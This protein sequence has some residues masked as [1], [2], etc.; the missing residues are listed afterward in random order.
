M[1]IRFRRRLY[2]C[3]SR[4]AHLGRKTHR[5]RK[6]HIWGI[7]T[8]HWFISCTGAQ[9][10][11]HYT[12]YTSAEFSDTVLP[13]SVRSSRRPWLLPCSTHSEAVTC[14]RPGA[15][16]PRQSSVLAKEAPVCRHTDTGE[17]TPVCRHIRHGSC[18][19]ARP[20]A[21]ARVQPRHQPPNKPS[22]AA[23][24]TDTAAAENRPL[25]A[26]ST[27]HYGAR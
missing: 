16:R 4:V 26:P 10:P 12:I 13:A 8:C 2:K 24:T 27:I 21:C 1:N 19:S 22:L 18:P 20:Q 3:R 7:Y 17:E 23:D 14:L 25:S 11:P 15:P 9:Q 6:L 5:P